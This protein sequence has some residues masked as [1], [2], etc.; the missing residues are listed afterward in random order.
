[1][2]LEAF[3]SP[4][5]V[6]V[7]GASENADKIGGR[8]I[9]YLQK[10]GFKGRIYPVN[11]ARD[12]VQGL[13][14]YPSIEALPQAPD[15]AVIAVPGQAAVDAIEACAARGVKAA[16][17]MASG[18]GEMGADGK[19]EEARLRKLANAAGMRLV[20]PNSQGL[21]NFGTGAIL[22]FSTMFIEAPPQDGP[23]ACIGQSGAM[24]VV[25]YGLLRE[26][27]IGVRHVHATGNDC[28]VT[29]SELA[30]A[31]IQDPAV[32]LM[33]LYLET[34]NDPAAL[35]HAAA[36]G[37]ARGVPIIAVKSGRSEDGR[38]AA[39]SH[40]GAIATADRVVDAFFERHGIW[41]ADGM[42]DLVRAA[43]LYLQG[44][45]PS[46]RRLAVI[47]N[48]GATCVLAADAADRARLP[49]AQLAPATEATLREI[50]PSFAAA[51]NP[52]DITAALLSNSALFDQVLPVVGADRSVD[53]FLIGLPVSGRGY[54]Y[55]RFAAD[56]AAFMNKSGKPVVLAAPQ[57]KV[58][59]AFAD[60]GVPVFATEDEAVTAL[61]QFVG[62]HEM[63]GAS[64]GGPVPAPA[65][66][67]EA[68]HRFLDE[69]RSLEL[70]E[71][72]GLATIVRRLC[73]DA[74]E[75]VGFLAEDG[76]PIVL[77]ACSGELP[78]KSELGLV[79]LGLKRPHEVEA[80]FADITAKLDSLGVGFEGVLA[81]RMASG[82]RELV[83]GGRIDPVFGP[84]VMLG[85]GGVLVE[86]MP[87]S[88]LL[89][90][91]FDAAAVRHALGRLRIGPLFAGVRGRPPLDWGAV[92]RAAEAV[93]ALLEKQAGRVRSVDVNPLLV[94]RD[95]AVAL[96]ALVEVAGNFE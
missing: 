16:V 8:P 47:S 70:L 79:R 28:D 85:D 10:F 39:A 93:A 3:L 13:T 53:L 42:L 83:V 37:R 65:P 54:D 80:A 52:I 51:R 55:P 89:L 73:R 50:L 90:T 4:R 87:D 30:A 20:G 81:E 26:R 43:E 18:F 6:A 35:A 7:I 61:A 19:A 17:V 68:P 21:A 44:W 92:A 76:G 78:H 31:V 45:K 15:A 23:V 2:S 69:H 86:A 34:L 94:S 91:P 63:L 49:M 32:K 96:D 14:A 9:S 40:T 25:P 5:S 56:T 62:H 24:T 38:R 48:S 60:L 57:P 74:A 29:V 72:H 27:G 22:S 66:V 64:Q 84:V 67:P 77:K 58:R 88:I 71:A 75:A 1:M 12:K 82:E 36:L 95:G 33:L 46:G 59:A 11:S 41:R